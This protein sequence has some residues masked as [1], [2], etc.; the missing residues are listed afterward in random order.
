MKRRRR[1][2]HEPID[3]GLPPPQIR[4]NGAPTWDAVHNICAILVRDWERLPESARLAYA[5]P[6]P[7]DRRPVRK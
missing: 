2:F 3:D 6:N 1:E 7:E 4:E 5:F